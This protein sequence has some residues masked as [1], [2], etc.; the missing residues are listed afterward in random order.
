MLFRSAELKGPTEITLSIVGQEKPVLHAKTSGT[1]YRAPAKLKPD[2]EY[3][4]TVS[5]GGNEIGTGRFRTL[6]MEAVQQVE[7]R[8]PSEKADFSDR[9]L[10]AMM[11]QE[12]GAT[13]EAQ[14]AWAKLAQERSDLPELAAL[15]K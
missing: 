3:L 5:I 15:A 12:L 14:E 9:L 13:Q 6:P 10:F 4:W 11:L 7:K 8:K 1:T 2:G